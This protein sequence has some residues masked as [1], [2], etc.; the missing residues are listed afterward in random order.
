MR[1]PGQS[2]CWLADVGFGDSFLE[3][4]SFEDH[5]EQVQDL[6][7]YRLEQVADGYIAWQRNYDGSW[8][9]QYYFDLQPRSFP[10][11]YASACHYH[12]TSPKFGFTQKG[13][14][15]IAT[16]EGRITLEETKLIITK[17]GQREEKLLK[18]R[19]EYDDL[20]RERFRVVL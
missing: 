8:E 9:R 19:Q 15:S 6:R 16:P 14:I 20:L 1:V 13:V 2:T 5:G 18:F 3:P 7:A 10:A 11:D 4:L 12:Q 17:N